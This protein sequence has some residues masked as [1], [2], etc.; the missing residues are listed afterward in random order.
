MVKD[1]LSSSPTVWLRPGLSE[2]DLNSVHGFL[3]KWWSLVPCTWKQCSFLWNLQH[4]GQY[5]EGELLLRAMF[6]C[7]LM[8]LPA[9]G[10]CEKTYGGSPVDEMLLPLAG[11]NGR[12]SFAVG[13]VQFVLKCSV[14]AGFVL[15]DGSS[16]EPEEM[17]SRSVFLEG[18]GHR[19]AWEAKALW[20]SSGNAQDSVR[21]R[22]VWSFITELNHSSSLGE[23]CCMCGIE[24]RVLITWIVLPLLPFFG[25]GCGFVRLMLAVEIFL[26][27]G[28]ST[29]LEN[30]DWGTKSG[31][32]AGCS[33]MS[34]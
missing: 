20:S 31:Q 14:R 9:Y 2:A 4:N 24:W 28:W 18:G 17:S 21:L 6:S 22:S 30:V 10:I 27:G 15:R 29:S 3:L 19:G 16:A 32:D 1:F 23:G 33:T 12:S 34:R 11:E 26:A 8:F 25:S 7:S 5:G 13:R